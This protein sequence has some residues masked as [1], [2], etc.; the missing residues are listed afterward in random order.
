MT[1]VG[2]YSI[3]IRTEH[4]QHKLDVENGVTSPRPAP[5]TRQRPK[6]G[7]QHKQA[8]YDYIMTNPEWAQNKSATAEA[9]GVSR[10]TLDKYLGELESEGYVK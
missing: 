2:A 8:I 6:F 10:P 4:R 9:I 5:T 3:A 1:L 7:S